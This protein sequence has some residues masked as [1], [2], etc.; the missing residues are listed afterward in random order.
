[1]SL[2]LLPRPEHDLGSLQPPPPGFKQ[3][4]CFGLLSSWDYRCT[5]PRLA[6]FCL[7]S[8]DGQA[9]LELLISSDP[10]ASASQSVGITGV[11]HRAWP[12]QQVLVNF[13]ATVLIYARYQAVFLTIAFVL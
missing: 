7:F 11:S 2:P 13:G 6:N 8:R 12:I 5:P 1:W 10:P 4:S 3:F 9:S